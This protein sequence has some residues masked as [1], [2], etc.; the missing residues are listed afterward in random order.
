MT[1][2]EV[3]KD[4]EFLP[5]AFL[6]LMA[7]MLLAP[8]IA[9]ARAIPAPDPLIVGSARRYYRHMASS[10]ATSER[11]AAGVVDNR[12]GSS[13]DPSAYSSSSIRSL[14]ATR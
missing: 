3:M 1:S 13:G 2:D 6:L 12:T 11:L 14:T 7:P 9:L 4:E 5:F 8:G 10:L